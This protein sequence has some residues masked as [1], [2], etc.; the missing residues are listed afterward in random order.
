MNALD[1]GYDG[2]PIPVR[3]PRSDWR[4]RLGN[5]ATYRLANNWRRYFGVWREADSGARIV[6]DPLFEKGQSSARRG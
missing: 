4:F 5:P 2:P 3:R 1:A 6:F